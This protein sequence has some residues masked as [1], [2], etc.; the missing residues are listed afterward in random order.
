[1]K[2][3][4]PV[5]CIVAVFAAC[6]QTENSTDN[7]REAAS[8][9]A[10]DPSAAGRPAT[11]DTANNTGAVST[12]EFA[13]RAATGGMMEVVLGELAQQKA[14]HADVKTLAQTITADHRAANKELIDISR[15][16]GVTLPTD[17]TSEQHEHH[18]RLEGLSGAEFDRAYVQM[19][20]EDHIQDIALFE[21]KANAVTSDAFKAFAAKTLPTLR[22][23]HE[24]AKA[25]QQK[26]GS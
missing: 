13:I 6:Q 18:A 1:M 24:M 11:T 20:V 5:I 7:A 10:I 12:D 4:L 22:K 21:A 23:H 26:L 17:M 9:D 19:M 8:G 25:A 14:T 3:L 15:A 16:K 2:N